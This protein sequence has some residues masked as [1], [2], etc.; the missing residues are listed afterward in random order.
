MLG[1]A[2]FLAGIGGIG[3]GLLVGR[4]LGSPRL[5]FPANYALLFILAGALFTPGAVAL[6]SI[7]EPASPARDRP[8]APQPRGHWLRAIAGDRAFRHFV[9]CQTLVSIASMAVPFYVGHAQLVL[10]VPDSTIGTFVI[11]QTIAGVVA[12]L[13][14]GLISDRWG[15]RYVI[16]IGSFAAIAAPIFALLAHVTSSPVLTKLYPAVFVSLGVAGGATW[17]GFFNYLLSSVPDENRAT[18]VG[19]ANT[20]AGLFTLAPVVG[21]WLL[22]TSSYTV[23]F[24]LTATLVSV[25]FVLTFRLRPLTTDHPS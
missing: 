9:S 22:Q 23:L 17:S 21:G 19:L 8:D 13:G 10:R 1:L 18:Y 25:G 15:P 20:I 3:A 11:A 16:S 4:I 6:A 5:L 12:N 7:R 2:Q 24:A 14:M